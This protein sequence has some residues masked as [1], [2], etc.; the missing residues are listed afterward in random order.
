MGF[1]D[2]IKKTKMKWK[3]G[4]QFYAEK[5]KEI[6]KKTIERYD[7][8]RALTYAFLLLFTMIQALRGK[9]IYALILLCTTHIHIMINQV[10]WKLRNIEHNYMKN[11]N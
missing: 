9:Y 4:K 10:W 7:N 6:T 1:K 2:M 8:Y 11:E 5:Q 3:V